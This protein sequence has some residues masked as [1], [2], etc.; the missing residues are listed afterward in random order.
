MNIEINAI[1]PAIAGAKNKVII[2]PTRAID[3][4][5]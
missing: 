2:P 4:P 3:A 5:N 1:K